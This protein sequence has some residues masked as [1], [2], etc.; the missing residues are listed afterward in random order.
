MQPIPAPST[1][2]AIVSEQTD[3]EKSQGAKTPP[4]L[5]AIFTL[6]HTAENTVPYPN[7]QQAEKER[8]H[9]LSKQSGKQHIDDSD[10]QIK[11]EE[12]DRRQERKTLGITS[13]QDFTD[14]VNKIKNAQTKSRPTFTNSSN[15]THF[16]QSSHSYRFRR[17]RDRGLAIPLR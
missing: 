3:E 13:V 9:H 2:A 17:I 14:E 8:D 1:A 15:P 5:S 11:Q 12:R 6:V 10:D 4:A 7:S 16:G